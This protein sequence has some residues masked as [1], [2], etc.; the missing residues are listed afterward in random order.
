M[1][2]AIK[3]ITIALSAT[4]FVSCNNNEFEPEIV[5]SQQSAVTLLVSP[6]G[7][8]DN[9]YNDVAAK[10]IFAFMEE[11]GVPVK[12]LQPGDMA[13]AETM[14][15]QWL[16]HN[17][18]AD[19]VVLVA[20]NSAYEEL[21]KRIPPTLIGRGSR[22]LLLESNERIEG[23]STVMVN[24]YGAAYLAGA[25]SKEFDAFILAAAPG[26]STLEDAIAGF[27]AGHSAHS[28]GNR[29]LTLQY[30]ADGEEGFA[31]PDSAYHTIYR[32]AE[33][34]WDYDEMIFPL[35]G[36]S[37]TGIT[38][39]LNGD[40]LTQALSIGMDVDQAGQSTRIPF[41]MVIRI[42]DIIKS[43]L[44]DWIIGKEWPSARR[45][46]LSEGATDIVI[47]P[48]FVDNVN[49]WDGRYEDNDAFLK[50]YNTYYKEAE[51]KEAEYEQK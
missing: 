47:T 13:E 1:R 25:M 12:L 23:V 8:G 17:A 16:S 18:S 15:Q 41:S 43:Y 10:G 5:V 19:S 40:D 22:V 35:L 34:N 44:D 46:G 24:R 6:N 26:F 33:Q 7:L 48:N 11:S 42:G 50:L 37:G 21:L 9:G 4:L 31:M 3:I 14:Y 32:R 38:K 45:I 36:G 28:S 29:Q 39:F 2:Q 30:L 27:R 51:R 49:I 20:G